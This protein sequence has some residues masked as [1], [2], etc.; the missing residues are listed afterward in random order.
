MNM[1]SN[2]V[3]TAK[4]Q[5]T[6]HARALSTAAGHRQCSDNATPRTRGAN[7]TPAIRK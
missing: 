6:R 4:P 2:S 7:P 5:Q 1:R 3:G